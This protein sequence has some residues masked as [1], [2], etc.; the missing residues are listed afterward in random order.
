[1]PIV[2]YLHWTL[3]DNFEWS[4]G[5]GPKFGLLANDVVT[6]TRSP[7]PAAREFAEV[8]RTNRLQPAR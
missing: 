2:G 7:R 5:T 3:M 1:V 8:C 4:L 6:Q